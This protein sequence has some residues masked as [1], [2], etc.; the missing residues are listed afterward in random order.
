MGG[1]IR[2][3]VWMGKPLALLVGAPLLV[4][5]DFGVNYIAG[6]ADVLFHPYNLAGYATTVVFAGTIA[7][8]GYLLNRFDDAVIRHSRIVY[9]SLAGAVVLTA[10]NLPL[11]S[12]TPDLPTW[13][14]V[15]WIYFA[16][17]GGLAGGSLAGLLETRAIARARAAERAKAKTE[18]ANEHSAQLEYLHGLLRHEVLNNANLINGYA[19]LAAKESDGEVDEHLELIV[20]RTES[21]TSVITDVRT[22]LDSLRASDPTSLE[23]VDLS[24]ILRDSIMEVREAN[25]ALQLSTSI[26]EDVYVLA[27]ELLSRVFSHILLNA[28]EHNDSSPPRIEVDLETNPETV[29]VRISDNGPG[30]P[31]AKRNTLFEGAQSGANHGLGLYLA[32]SLVSRYDGSLELAETGPDGSTFSVELPRADISDSSRPR[33]TTAEPSPVVS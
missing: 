23:P 25:E 11:I 3:N 24:S 14:A 27:D 17:V 12:L 10:L 26:P 15:S 7:V 31:E 4:G 29:T 22:L 13:R 18:L 2:S 8:C 20:D 16:M 19:E 28:L 1:G 21:M 6:G 33:R 30:I 32:D 5:L 9:W